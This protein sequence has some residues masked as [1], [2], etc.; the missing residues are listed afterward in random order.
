MDHEEEENSGYNMRMKAPGRQVKSNFEV[1]AE[2][3]E[4]DI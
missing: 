1:Y 2:D 3:I 4:E